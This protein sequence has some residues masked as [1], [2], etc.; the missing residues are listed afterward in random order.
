MGSISIKSS[1]PAQSAHFTVASEVSQGFLTDCLS[2]TVAKGDKS[3]LKG[4]SLATM[5]LSFKVDVA[6]VNLGKLY[7]YNL[8]PKHPH[9][10]H[11][12]FKLVIGD[13]VANSKP[14]ATSPN[15]QIKE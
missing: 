10:Q 2:G 13:E 9:T 12:V 1:S 8:V 11:C 7:H 15:C 4:C 14:Q 3:E 5:P 6:I